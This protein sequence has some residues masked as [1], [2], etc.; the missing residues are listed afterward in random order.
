MQD[1]A[2]L[3]PRAQARTMNSSSR[4]SMSDV[5]MIISGSAMEASTPVA[6]GSTG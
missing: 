3:R 5:R 4:T 1:D 2:A 6:T